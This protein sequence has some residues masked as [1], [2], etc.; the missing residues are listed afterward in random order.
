MPPRSEEML[1]TYEIARRSATIT[2]TIVDE[3]QIF[4]YDIRMP[5]AA[6]QPYALWQEIALPLLRHIGE[7]ESDSWKKVQFA[8]ELAA[9]AGLGD[10]VNEV[11]HE[12]RRL[13]DDGYITCRHEPIR[14]QHGTEYFGQGLTGKGAR[15]IEQW[16]PNDLV[17]ALE[18]YIDL[19]INKADSDEERQPWERLKQA[20]K[21]IPSHLV[22]AVL[23]MAISAAG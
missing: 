10:R 3:S 6:Q 1:T 8:E 2:R 19:Q 13:I 23:N 20:I 9:E 22:G 7:N 4:I 21:D 11:D 18:S 15:A 17:A 5:E 12:M 14:L 16:P